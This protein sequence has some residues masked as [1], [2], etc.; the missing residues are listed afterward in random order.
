MKTK[1]G[2]KWL[3]GAVV[4]L[5]L[6]AANLSIYHKEQLLKHGAVVILELAPVDPRS[7]MQGDYMALNYAL[8]QPLQQGLYEQGETCRTTGGQ[9]LPSNGKLVVTLDEQRRAVS[10]VMDQGQPLHKQER[11]LQYHL[12]GARLNIG[13]PSYF[14][15]EGHAERFEKA[16]YGE[17]RVADDGTALLT[18]M[19]DEKGARILP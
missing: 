6:A 16:R 19:L 9:C 5:V 3:A 1:S 17:F 15:Q 18:Y 13:T 11:L 14:F 10:A 7:L 12:S 4:L 2:L 8:V